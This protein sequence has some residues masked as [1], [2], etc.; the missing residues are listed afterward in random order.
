MSLR[1]L[2]VSDY[3]NPVSSRPEAEVMI[4]LKKAGIDIEI[5]TYPEAEYIERFREEGLV[6][7]TDHP[8]SKFSSSEMKKL[9]TR[10]IEGKYQV[11]HLFNNNAIVTGLRAAKGVPIKVVLYRGYTGNINWWDP[12]AYQKFLS[13][14]VDKIT[15]LAKSIEELLYRQLFFKKDKAITINK[16][17]D[18][19]WYKDVQAINRKELPVPENAFIISNVAN[20]R[21]M[22]GI[23]YLLKA[24][25]KMPEGLP[26]HLL[27]IGRLMDTEENLKL[28]RNSPNADKIHLLGFRKDVLSIVAAS[29][30]FILPSIKGE[31]TTK[32]AIEAMSLGIC[33]IISDIS[34]N[35]ELVIDGE[36]GI[37]FKKKN[38]EAIIEAVLKAYNDKKLVAKLGK[39]AKERIRTRFNIEQTVTG[40][41][42]LYEEL[43]SQIKK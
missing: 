3:R 12:T 27:I 8:R 31:A 41:K 24:F 32:A 36:S 16:G 2:V 34:G 33:P 28:I 22:K 23:P 40:Y 19:N 7:H 6:V 5:M 26:I 13:P 10:F 20:N 14:R 42:K 29:D 18:L 39:A 37:V 11:A 15:C 21:R 30:A 25:A 43:A 38:P 35:R 1:V 17:H 4:R 9:R